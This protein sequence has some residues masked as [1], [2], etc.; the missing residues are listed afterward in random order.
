MPGLR[1]DLKPVVAAIG[2]QGR[3]QRSAHSSV[4][5]SAGDRSIPQL[6]TSWQSA[7]PIVV[8]SMADGNRITKVAIVGVREYQTPLHRLERYFWQ[9][10]GWRQLRQVHHRGST[11]DWKAH[12]H[13]NHTNRQQEQVAKR[14]DL[15][16]GRL[17]QARDARW[18]TPRPRCAGYYFE[19]VHSERDWTAAYHR[20]WWGRRGMDFAKWMVSRHGERGAG[21]RCVCFSAK[22]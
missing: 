21:Q 4:D 5:H 11:H 2:I 12:Y 14:R 10:T 3:W 16:N 1:P 18:S 15:Q 9:T 6:S 17:Q 22:R 19:W 20:C 8:L 13:S 7:L